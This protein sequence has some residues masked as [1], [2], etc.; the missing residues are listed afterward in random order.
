MAGTRD[1]LQPLSAVFFSLRARVWEL[2]AA[3]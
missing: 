2:I 1:L 3:N